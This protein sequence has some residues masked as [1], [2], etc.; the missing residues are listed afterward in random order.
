MTL[1]Q[2]IKDNY[3]LW[4]HGRAMKN[5]EYKAKEH[6]TISKDYFKLEEEYN[7]A[8]RREEDRLWACY[9]KKSLRKYS[10]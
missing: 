2:I 5:I 4:H 1:I 9:Q 6:E 3:I 7:K 10:L 8:A